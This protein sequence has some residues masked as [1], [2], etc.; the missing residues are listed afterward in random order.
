MK[1]QCV[2]VGE[3]SCL[4]LTGVYEVVTNYENFYTI[5]I[6]GERITYT[7]KW[8]IVIDEEGKELITPDKP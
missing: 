3:F 1:V 6:E 8:F 5:I 4:H 2:D 7:K